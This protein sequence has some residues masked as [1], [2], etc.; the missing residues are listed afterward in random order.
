MIRELIRDALEVIETNDPRQP[1]ISRLRHALGRADRAAA[2]FEAMPPRTKQVA[3]LAAK[4][5]TDPQIAEM[6]AIA[7]KT[8]GSIRH[9]AMDKVGVDSTAQ[10]AVLAYRAGVLGDGDE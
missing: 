5:F 1:V 10:L 6:L 7:S 9:N 4:G 2:L 8:V 3:I